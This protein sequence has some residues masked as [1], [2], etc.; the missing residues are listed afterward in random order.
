[1]KKYTLI[2]GLFSIILPGLGQIHNR[3]PK[4]ALVSCLVLAGSITALCLAGFP[5]H[6][7]GLAIVLALLFSFYF[8]S[9][10]DAIRVSLRPGTDALTANG[11]LQQL[12][13]AVV[14]LVS[15]FSIPVSAKALGLRAFYLPTNSMAPTISAGDSIMVDMNYY[16]TRQP[17]RGEVVLISHAQV[18]FVPKRII[19]VE[20]DSIKSEADQVYINGNLINE[21]Y[22]KFIGRQSLDRFNT[23]HVALDF[24]VKVV[25]SGQLF[26][27]GDNRDNSFDSRDPEFGFVKVSDVL[28]KPLYIYWSPAR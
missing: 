15:A 26:V 23:Q 17:A 28:G 1:M 4:K 22:A 16:R 10:A 19:A 12:F 20:G 11:K 18:P 8:W 6:F 2:A 9:V 27:M 25:P 7:W 24:A 13:F 5:Y 3:Q 14:L 21:P